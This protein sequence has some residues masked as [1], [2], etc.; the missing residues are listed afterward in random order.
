MNLATAK[1]TDRSVGKEAAGSKESS[2]TPS[3]RPAASVQPD[4]KALAMEAARPVLEARLEDL[5]ATLV[6]KLMPP[7]G[8][9]V[10]D[11]RHSPA[12][13]RAD[14][15]ALLIAASKHMDPASSA[16]DRMILKLLREAQKSPLN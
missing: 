4:Y 11:V 7:K 1:V 16:E 10:E 3:R 14:A 13:Y 5:I 2:S 8:A 15:I 6:N 9:A 12:V